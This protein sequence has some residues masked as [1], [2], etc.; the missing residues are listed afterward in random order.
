MTKGGSTVGR[1][2]LRAALRLGRVSNLP[3]IWTDVVAGIVLSG[4]AI[5]TASTLLLM[6]SL[7]LF[8]V[9]GMFLNDA[10][11][12]E[13]DRRDRSHRPIPAGEAPAKAVFTYGFALLAAGFVILAVTACVTTGS[14]G[15]RAVAAGALLGGVIILYDAWHKANPVGPILMGLCRFL[16]YIVAGLAVAGTIPSRLLLAAIVCLCYL[17]GLTYIAKQEGFRRIGNLWPLLFL[18]VP[19]AY[20]APYAVQGGAALA[21][22]VLLLAAVGVALLLIFALNSPDI[23]HAV[24]LLIAGI[25]VLDGLFMAAHDQTL[26]AVASVAA[27]PLTLGLQRFVPGT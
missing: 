1:I 19:F 25:C 2:N 14:T 5:A 23:P 9:A 11:D 4:A 12:R 16:V 8:Y 10:F 18:A 13:F 27:F 15:W 3:T 24:M 17:I 21:L 26:L 6:L 22:Y 20:G 7:S